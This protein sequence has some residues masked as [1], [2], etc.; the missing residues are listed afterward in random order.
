[1]K[2]IAKNEVPALDLRKLFLA[3]T[4]IL[5]SGLV[6]VNIAV[7]VLSWYFMSQFT[8]SSLTQVMTICGTIL[9]LVASIT[10]MILGF[11]VIIGGLYSYRWGPPEGIISIG[12][13]AGTFYL[14]CLGIGSTLLEMSLG[15]LLLILS[16]VLFMLGSAAYTSSSL[17]FKLIGSITGVI[18]GIVLAIAVFNLQIFGQ[19][20]AGWDVAFTGPFM[21]MNIME[22]IVMILAPVAVL[23]NLILTARKQRSVSHVF[24][25]I[26]TL[27]YGIGMFIGS[28]TLA[29][30]LWDKLWKSPWLPPFYGVPYWVFGATIFWS[31]SLIILAI[32]G[33]FL[34]TTSGLTFASIAK[35][36]S[37][38]SEMSQTLPYG[39]IRHRLYKERST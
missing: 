13:L 39:T 32:G 34:V 28:L 16:A 36:A 29:L 15:G 22:E 2:T 3:T 21:S 12:V 1:M 9:F 4:T 5:G 19:V 33:I 30:S 24:F 11:F 17:D 8:I 14:L 20:F 6:L 37:V 38:T 31:V 35:E 25:P 27:I 10:M 23:A 18:G 26:V 7:A